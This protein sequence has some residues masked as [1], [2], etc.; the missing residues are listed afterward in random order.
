MKEFSLQEH[1]Y[2]E[3]NKLLKITGLCPSGGM[4]KQIIAAGE[5]TL[6][7]HIELRKRCKILSGQTIE[8]A[9]QKVTVID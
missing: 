2:I 5:V 3:L 7:G 4:A 9:G 6:D 1:K 8:F